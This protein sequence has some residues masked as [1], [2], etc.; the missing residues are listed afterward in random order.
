MLRQIPGLYSLGPLKNCH[1]ELWFST[2]L[3]AFIHAVAI[4]KKQMS[5]EHLLDSWS[6]C[7]WEHLPMYWS[8]SFVTSPSQKYNPG[9]NVHLCFLLLGAKRLILILFLSLLRL[10]G[11]SVLIVTLNF[12]DLRLLKIYF[13]FLFSL[14]P[15]CASCPPFKMWLFLPTRR[16]YGKESCV[17]VKDACILKSYG[18]AFQGWF[19]WLLDVYF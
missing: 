14:L 16:I 11:N 4:I 19:C 5:A 1:L 12:C 18:T 8:V 2:V 7:Y 10:P 9:Q 15:S 17:V 3:P 6:K 13:Y